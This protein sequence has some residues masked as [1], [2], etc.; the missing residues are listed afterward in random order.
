MEKREIDYR[1]LRTSRKK[2]IGITV[3]PSCEVIIHAPHRIPVEKI[4]E[5]V[6]KRA[7]WIRKR[8]QYWAESPKAYPAKEYVSGEQFLYLGRSYRLK[9]VQ[10]NGNDCSLPVI[11]G[12]R[13]CIAVGNRLDGVARLQAMR[14][15]LKT[16][17][18]KQAVRVIKERVKRYAPLLGVRPAAIMVRDQKS[19]WGSCSTKGTLRF[20]W[21][22]VLAPMRIIDYV[23]VHEL[24]HLKIRNHSKEFWRQVSMALLDYTNRRAWLKENGHSLRI[25]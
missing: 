10:T 15:R 14:S 6:R 7:S 18:L 4:H 21:R 20:N 1:I 13:L 5:V 19:R 16:W 24:C 25:I 17:Y 12:R 2:T 23:V 22:S 3:K 8:L 9:I 11:A